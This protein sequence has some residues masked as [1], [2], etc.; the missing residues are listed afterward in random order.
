M[1]MAEDAMIEI[2]G[3]PFPRL[4]RG[5]VRDVFDLGDRLLI[6]ATD[7]LSAFDVVLPTPI[8]GKGRLLTAISDFWFD[9]TQHLVPNHH[10]GERI[11]E[12]GLTADQA[13]AIAAR[14]AIV[15]KAERIDVECIVR[16]HLA[17]SGWRE[18]EKQGTLAGERLP[19][20]L[21]RGDRLPEPCFTP[22]AKYDVGHDE[23]ISRSTMAT[24]IGDDMA[25]R[26]ERTSID[27]FLF[28]NGIAQNAGFVVADTKFEFGLIDGAL[29]L[30]DEALTPD[31]SRY[32]DVATWVA[33]A[34]P[35]SFDKQA[36]R[37]WLE[38]SGWNKEPPG[39]TLPA[40]IVESTRRK[41]AEVLSRLTS[42]EKK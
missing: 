28:A 34:E 15:W 19:S 4:R 20:G 12:L 23:N 35:P 37:D 10:T 1:P 3:V 14:S 5:K 42:E 27:L 40:D 11:D 39:P 24:M 21:R 29:T 26:L 16:G 17:G 2:D 32:W 9:R 41:Y 31:S 7:R 18:Y 13:S 38:S 33:D 30:I 22:A 25:N 6:V 8:P 36:V